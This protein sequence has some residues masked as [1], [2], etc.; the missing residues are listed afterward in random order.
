MDKELGNVTPSCVLDI[1]SNEGCAS[2][3]NDHD[4]AEFATQKIRRWWE[5]MGRTRYPRA[6]Q[7]LITA[8][9]GGSNGVRLRLFAQISKNW[10]GRPLLSRQLVLN[11]IESTTSGSGLKVR[12]ALDGDTDPTKQKVSDEEMAA[13]KID[14]AVEVLSKAICK[15]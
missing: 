9:G 3:E 5:E 11:L 4:T 13:M 6:R 1:T 2:F 14:R 7:L 12:A 10:R 8:D 15:L